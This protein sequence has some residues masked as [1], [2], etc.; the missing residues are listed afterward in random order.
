M[1]DELLGGMSAD[2][3]A[4]LQYSWPLWAREEQ[5]PPPG[6]WRVWFYLGGRGSGKTRAMAEHIRSEV[7]SGRRRSIGIIGPTMEAVR[8]VMVEGPSGLLAVH[9]PNER[10][11]YEVS[12]GRLTWPNGAQAHLFSAEEPDRLRGPNFDLLW[13]DELCAM[14]NDTAVWDMSM[15]ALRLPGPMGDPAQ[16]VVSTTPRPTPL[17]K[18]IIAAPDT[19]VTK[20]RTLDNAAN[21]DPNTLVYLQRK[22]A[23]TTLGRQELEA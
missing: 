16:A 3:L 8:R 7:M 2:A 10:P 17:V 23:N 12:I 11:T 18:S 4:A 22:Y 20:S 19:V 5:L 21:L 15:M 14:P 6:R 1:R 9:P 13:I